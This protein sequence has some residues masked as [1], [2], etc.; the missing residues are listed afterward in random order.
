[1]YRSVTDFRFYDVSLKKYDKK[2]GFTIG[3]RTDFVKRDG[4]PGPTRYN[5]ISDFR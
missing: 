1:M 3:K 2:I 5:T 4:V